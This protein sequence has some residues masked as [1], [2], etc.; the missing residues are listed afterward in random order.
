MSAS[1]NLII[2]WLQGWG[3]KV[4]QSKTEICVFHC[5]YNILTNIEAD[6]EL[7]GLKSS[8]N[9]LGKKFDSRL[10]WTVQV[11]TSIKKAC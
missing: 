6:G 1:L 3:L 10:Q 11:S 5:N 2:K 8:I 9:V 7:E 4:N